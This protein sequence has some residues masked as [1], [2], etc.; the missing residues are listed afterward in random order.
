MR[1]LVN[2]PLDHRRKLFRQKR[3]ICRAIGLNIGT[4]TNP[5]NAVCPLAKVEKIPM[6][7]SDGLATELI[8]QCYLC[9]HAP[10]FFAASRIRN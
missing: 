10:P 7:V 5:K 9:K 2:F 3:D 6:Y 8:A 1:I 4:L